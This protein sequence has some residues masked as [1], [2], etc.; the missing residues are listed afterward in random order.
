MKYI[1]YSILRINFISMFEKISLAVN[2]HKNILIL[3]FVYLLC[4]LLMLPLRDFSF[5]DDFAYINTVK[6][7]YHFNTLKISEWSAATLVFQVYWGLLFVKLFGWSIK[8]LHLSNIVLLYFALIAFYKLLVLLKIKKG[9]S[10]VFTLFL[11]GF[12][13]VF[14]FSYTFMTDVFYISL[15]I[16]ATYFYSKGLVHNKLLSLFLGSIFSGFAF[17]S[18]QLGML[19]PL[20]FV[21]ILVL[22]SVSKKK[23]EFKK[24]IYSLC[25]FLIILFSYLG[26]LKTIGPTLGQAYAFKLSPY[27]FPK[28]L[29]FIEVTNS[30]WIE[31]LIQRTLGYL[32]IAIVL[33]FPSFLI[34]NLRTKKVLR[35]LK[36]NKKII[37]Y[38]A[39][40]V[41]FSYF[42]NYVYKEKWFTKSTSELIFQHLSFSKHLYRLWKPMLAIGWVFW[43]YVIIK[44]LK[45]INIVLQNKKR[46]QKKIYKAAA[47]LILTLLTVFVVFSFPKMFPLDF[48]KSSVLY[49]KAWS[50]PFL[51]SSI[52]LGLQT[53][54]GSWFFVLSIFGLIL[55]FFYLITHKRISRFDNNKLPL[56]FVMMSFFC[57]LFASTFFGYYFWEEYIIS[58]IP[59]VVII[60]AY[61]LKNIPIHKMKAV[62]IVFLYFFL[63]LT[64]TNKNYQTMGKSWE[65]AYELV[66]SG[67]KPKNIDT[68]NWAWMPYW[69]FD[70]SLENAIKNIGGNKYDL[71]NK[72]SHWYDVLPEGDTLYSIRPGNNYKEGE[73][74]FSSSTFRIL[75]RK[76]IMS[77]TK[78]PIN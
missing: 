20:A 11:F 63:S 59:M 68:N 56:F 54:K 15:M 43:I 67:I 27:L 33:L 38:C 29:G 32:Q 61:S 30:L 23:I 13:W 78:K 36:Q 24:Y 41:L 31:L 9:H 77:V 34:F 21:I 70:S 71:G 60:I 51:V 62:I 22:Q 19:I 7:L 2:K 50:I 45:E 35:F 37:F 1:L 10:L 66:E 46:Q 49:H 57:H 65:L 58:I 40:F 25:P 3:T 48:G 18:R 76:N 52:K 39:F 17:L 64:I 75:L 5:T 47:S 74:L 44:V 72:I 42:V 55:F 4:F 8:A 69:Y 16:I 14:F 53:I 73:D 28:S 26:W 6:H 12:P